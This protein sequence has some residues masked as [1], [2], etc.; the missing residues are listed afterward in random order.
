M[1][2]LARFTLAGTSSQDLAKEFGE[3][4]PTAAVSL[5]M[6]EVHPAVVSGKCGNQYGRLF[7]DI[8]ARVQG[9]ESVC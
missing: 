9:W 3:A 6:G 5:E 1:G 7:I 8:W 4:A 2:Y